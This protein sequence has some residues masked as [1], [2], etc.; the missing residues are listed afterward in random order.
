MYTN[1][2]YGIIS[3]K[4]GLD[5]YSDIHGRLYRGRG[6]GTGP[7]QAICLVRP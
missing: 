3:A 4:L 7:V 2:F 1:V 5:K 6:T